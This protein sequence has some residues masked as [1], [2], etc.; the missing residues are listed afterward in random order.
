MT[1]RHLTILRA[2]CENGCNTTRAAEALHMTQPAV[3]LAL[4]ELEQYYGTV[5]F[6][7]IGRRLQITEGGK[8][9]LDYAKHILALYE[10]MERDMRSWDSQGLLRIGASI[11]I[12]SQFLPGY[13]KAFQ[14]RRPGTQISALVMPSDV[15]EEKIVSSEI[16]LALIEGPAHRENVVSE[17]Y[18]DDELIA[19]AP[20]DSALVPGETVSLEFFMRQPFLLREHGSG[21]REVFDRA[22]EQAGYSVSPVWEAMSTTALVRAVSSGLGVAVLPSRMMRGAVRSG[23]VTP[24][25]VEGLDFRRRFFIIHHRQKHLT[26]AMH[27]FIDLCRHYEDDYPLPEYGDLF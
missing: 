6:D 3:S 12:G 4:R 15:L 19:I 18:M 5:L 20:P 24:I 27:L 7:R 26:T 14:A 8:R 9:F 13:V 21:T 17:A 22:I 23:Q 10:D 1:I 11:T 25:R 16:D 2:V